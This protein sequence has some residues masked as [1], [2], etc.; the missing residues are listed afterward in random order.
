MR[1]P[2][3]LPEPDA[4][5]RTHVE[6]ML[7]LI[8]AEIEVGG[9]AIPFSRYMEIGALMRRG[10][11]TTGPDWRIVR[12]R[13]RLRHRA[14]SFLPVVRD[15]RWRARSSRSCRSIGARRGHR[16]RRR[17]G[18]GWRPG[19]SIDLSCREDDVRY[20]I[21][22]PSG[23]LVPPGS[24]RPSPRGRP[25][26]SQRVSW[27]DALP[28]PGFRGRRAGQ[29]GRRRLAG[30][31]VRGDRGRR[32]RCTVSDSTHGRPVWRACPA[33]NP[34]S[35]EAVES[36]QRELEHKTSGRVRLRDRTGAVRL[37]G[38]RRGAG[39]MRP[40]APDGLRISPATSSTTP[41]A[42]TARC[43]A[44]SGTAVTTIH[45]CCAGCR[46]FRHMSTSRR[47]L[48]PPASMWRDSPPRASF[49][50]LVDCSIWSPISFRRA[51]S[52]SD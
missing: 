36:L 44:T 23:A 14:P 52:S 17:V 18:D 9:G 41:T 28:E 43:D 1:P 4:G 30:G 50:S 29:R 31:A 46:T 19:C 48:V 16:D 11:D 38:Q 7:A 27:L 12:R 39:G 15:A 37:G 47:S 13:R 33:A 25:M 5:E 32:P 20:R 42:V 10:S 45:S 8:Q 49:S 40:R 24:G 51:L 21:L 2:P 26:R 34:G 3:V 22:E 35:T 6:Q